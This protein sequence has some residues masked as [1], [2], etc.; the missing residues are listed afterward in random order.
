MTRG[1]FLK[2]IFG[3]PE[4]R[5]LRVTKVAFR[6]GSQLS[7]I[8]FEELCQ[9]A[10]LNQAKGEVSM[11]DILPAGDPA[12][13]ILTHANENDRSVGSP[14]GRQGEFGWVAGPG[15]ISAATKM[16]F[17]QPRLDNAANGNGLPT[18]HI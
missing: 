5:L 9:S 10:E 12:G 8:F 14:I 3:N 6:K 1:S 16:K 13:C 15:K 11:R 18:G 2:S 17:D 4:F 7:E